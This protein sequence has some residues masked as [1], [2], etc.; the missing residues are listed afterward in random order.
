MRASERVMEKGA[1]F[2]CDFRTQ[3]VFDFVRAFVELVLIHPKR[4][5]EQTLG[6]TMAADRRLGALFAPTGQTEPAFRKRYPIFLRQ[7]QERCSIV[8]ELFQTVRYDLRFP[9]IFAGM[10]DGLQ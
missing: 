6:Q 4:I 1:D 8:S 5:E 9:G 3:S 7:Q 10:P 2:F